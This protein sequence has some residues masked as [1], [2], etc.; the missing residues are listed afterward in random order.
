MEILGKR[1]TPREGNYAFV[2]AIF[3]GVFL[4]L[5]DKGSPNCE[6]RL[7]I[8]YQSL[9]SIYRGAWVGCINFSTN[10]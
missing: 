5:I 10:A 8:L 6:Y 2:K 3:W 1:K 7:Y 4:S 9:P